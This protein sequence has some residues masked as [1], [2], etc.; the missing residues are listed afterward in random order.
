MKRKIIGY[1]IVMAATI[2]MVVIDWRI[3]LVLSIYD[4]GAWLAYE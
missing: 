2:A 1:L 4:I 3:G